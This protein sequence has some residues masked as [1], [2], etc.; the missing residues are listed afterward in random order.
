MKARHGVGEARSVVRAWLTAAVALLAWSAGTGTAG[1][2]VCLL[3]DET[4]ATR[5][6]ALLEAADSIVYDDWFEPVPIETVEVRPYQALFEVVVNGE[7][8]PD[9]AYTYVPGEP[10]W[11]RNISLEIGCE[12]A[13]VTPVV[14]GVPFASDAGAAPPPPDPSIPRLV[15]VVEVPRAWDA[16]LAMGELIE[17]VVI[18]AGPDDGAS[19][20]A[21]AASLDAFETIDIDYEMLGAAVYGR[22]GDWFG[23]RVGEGAG[24]LPPSEAGAFYPYPDLLIERLSYLGE[25]WDGRLYDAP[26]RDAPRARLDEAWRR[27]MGEDIVV[28]VRGVVRMAQGE[29]WVR[30]DVVWPD[31]CGGDEPVPVASGWVPAY[32]AAGSPN[33]WF[34]SRGC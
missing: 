23:V 10:G 33:V 28:D 8:V 1:A 13:D 11:L 32:A 21:K 17:P 4:T 3:M 12:G 7:V 18:R 9:A 14:P 19:I 31:P 20:V 22:A 29:A 16:Y 34:F 15:G 5:F 26:A 25:S 27:M 24:W 30:L 6:A 2:D